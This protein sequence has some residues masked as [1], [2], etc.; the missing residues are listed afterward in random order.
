MPVRQA[1]VFVISKGKH[2]LSAFDYRSCLAETVL[3]RYRLR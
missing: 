3:L 1:Y 2:F